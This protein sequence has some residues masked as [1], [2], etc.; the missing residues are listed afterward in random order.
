MSDLKE[1]L[2]DKLLSLG[3]GRQMVALVDQ[4]ITDYPDPH[5]LARDHASRI[6]AKRTGKK[7][8]PRFIWW[9][10]FQGATSSSRSFNGWQHSGPPMKSMRLPALVVQRFDLYFQD[11]VDELDLY[12]G[13]Y[14]QGAYASQF[15]EN[16]EVPMLGRD[17]QADLWALDFAALY[18]EL[19]DGFW[20]KHAVTF[21]MLAKINLL[22][23]I[24]RA[25]RAG[26][27]LDS[28]AVALRRMT[29]EG[30]ESLRVFPT[31][32][33]LRKSSSS[34]GFT[35]RAYLLGRRSRACFYS[36]Q[37]TA[38]R[39]FLYLPWRSEALFAFD[40]D[41]AMASWLRTQLQDPESFSDFRSAAIDNP[42][43]SGETHQVVTLLQGI[44]GSR[45]DEAALALLTLTHEPVSGDFFVY[46]GDHAK[47]EM[48]AHAAAMQDNTALRKSMWS[49]YLSAFLNIFLGFAPLGWPSTLVLLGA[50]LGRVGLDVDAAVHASSEESRKAS[51]RLAVLDTLFAALNLT[52]LGFRSSFALLTYP[53]PFHEVDASLAGWSV[54]PEPERLLAG[55][56]VNRVLDAQLQHEGRLAGILADNAGG[57][58][59]ELGG[60][61]YRVRYSY[62]LSVWLVVPDDNPLAFGPLYPVQLDEHGSWQLLVPPIHAAPPPV[63]GMLSEVSPLWDEYMKNSGYRSQ[64]LSAQA[65]ARQKKLLEGESIPA[66]GI[67]E[68]PTADAHGIAAVYHDGKLVHTYREADGQ[69]ANELINY[70]TDEA[71]NVN[72]V[73]REGVHLYADTASY[74]KELADAIDAL[75]KS[76]AVTLFR[77]GH[78]LRGTSGAHFRS[79]RLKTGDIL[80]NTDLTSWTENP[81]VTYTFATEQVAE[82]ASAPRRFDDTSVI[83][84]LPAKMYQS[85]TPISAFSMY[86]DEAETVFL[87]GHYFRIEKLSQVYGV[88]Y[89]FVHVL[90]RQVSRPAS[91]LAYDLRTGEVFDRAAFGER[92]RSEQLL[93][94]FF[95]L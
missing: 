62:R 18:R 90:L 52:D 40:T 48:Q 2:H 79:G 54:A 94:R 32:A 6:L 55:K 4:F 80:V 70:Y 8:D 82:P 74:I 17:V 93:N 43:D 15:D 16:N 47:V 73:L 58:W 65:R 26:A 7:R 29:V 53:T 5:S 24:A 31:L 13:F 27:L 87:P 71:A 50:S 83:F 81:Y 49:G 63:S 92:L 78:G 35:V 77:G 57:C 12:G 3:L 30:L 34:E 23:E 45:S 10:Q 39:V 59:I 20:S 68:S 14:K 91:G 36:I 66:L 44:V 37:P 51:L 88:D 42:Y 67:G 41:L 9:H 86:W 33:Q 11:A 61:N 72:T 64:V 38:G 84:E 46:L 56:E 19:V 75:P 22:G 1:R 25:R 89:R 60:L 28:E 69:Y 95:P 76:N 21:G 85:G